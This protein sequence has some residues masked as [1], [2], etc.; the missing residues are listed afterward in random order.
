MQELPSHPSCIRVFQQ[1][2]L[3][4]RQ[5]QQLQTMHEEKE[6]G[7]ETTMEGTADTHKTV[8][9]EALPSLLPNLSHKVFLPDRKH[10]GWL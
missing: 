2:A 7:A 4:G 9:G 6:P 1:H 10:E 5:E 3:Q 8:G